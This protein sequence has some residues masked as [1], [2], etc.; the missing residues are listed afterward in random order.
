VFL[1]LASILAGFL[2]SDS[3]ASAG[4]GLAICVGGG[5]V[6]APVLFGIASW[7]ASKV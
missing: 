6:A 7:V 4:I 3:S 2:A 5:L 1:C